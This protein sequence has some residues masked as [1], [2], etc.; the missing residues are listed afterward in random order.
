MKSSYKIGMALVGSFVLGV[1]AASVL[2][3]QTKPQGYVLVEVDVKDQDGY[4][5]DFLPRRKPTSK[6]ST[7]NTSPGDL[8][9]RSALG[10]PRRLI[11]WYSYNSVIWT[12]SRHLKTKRGGT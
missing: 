8:T 4:T 9:K 2:H 6:N 5:K 11:A 1:G 10:E 3:A 7:A 12:R